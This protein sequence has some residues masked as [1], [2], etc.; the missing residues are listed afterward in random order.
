[1]IVTIA[2]G[3]IIGAMIVG[4]HRMLIVRTILRTGQRRGQATQRERG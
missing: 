4:T 2:F 1:M 3:G